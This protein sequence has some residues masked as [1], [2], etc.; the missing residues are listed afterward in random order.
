MSMTLMAQAMGIRVGHPIRKL[1]LLKLADN[2]NDKGECWPSYQHIADHCECHKST[3]RAHVAVLI[4]MGLVQKKNRLGVNN[5]KG[6]TSN[7]YQ[8]TLNTPV[9][10]ADTGGYLSEC[11]P[12]VLREDI[13]PVSGEDI[14]MLPQDTPMPEPDT[15]VLCGSTPPVLCGSTRISHSFEPVME[16]VKEPKECQADELP[17]DFEPP[18]LQVLKHLNRVTGAQFLEGKTT[19]GFIN[20]LLVG[21]Y[22]A[23][24]LILVIDHRAE[25]WAHDTKMSQHLCPKT[26]FG[27]ENFEGYLP[28]ARKWD[29]DGRPPLNVQPVEIDTEERDQAYRRFTGGVILGTRGALEMAVRKSAAT[30]GIKDHTPA[31]GKR[32]WDRLWAEHARRLSSET[33]QAEA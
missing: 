12:P 16:P 8:L 1:V 22:V 3:A 33:N 30:G 6:N 5:G 24:E 31:A 26:L 19:M 23:D 13:A 2:A 7:Y 17:D 4:K 29:S 28:L 11:D 32:E 27:F 25:L 15:P 18:D 10:C 14:A 21:E 9:S 20:G